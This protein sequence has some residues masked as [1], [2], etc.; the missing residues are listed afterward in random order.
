VSLQQTA[1]PQSRWLVRQNLFT[2][3]SASS[4]EP[5]SRFMPSWAPFSCADKLAEKHYWLICCERKTLFWLKK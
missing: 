5:L 3:A 2:K 4:F 1:Q